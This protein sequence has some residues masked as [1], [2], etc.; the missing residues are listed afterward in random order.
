MLNVN[1]TG[2]NE[3]ELVAQATKDIDVYENGGQY[4]AVQL[5]DLQVIEKAL[6]RSEFV[7]VAGGAETR[8]RAQEILTRDAGIQFTK[9]DYKPQERQGITNMKRNAE[10]L[11]CKSNRSYK[12]VGRVSR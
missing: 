12:H 10:V 5:N 6:Q 8:K 9:K 11:E 4:S 3:T 7:G 2:L 1:Y